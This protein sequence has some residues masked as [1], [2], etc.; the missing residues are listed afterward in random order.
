MPPNAKRGIINLQ[1]VVLCTQNKL[2][3]ALERGEEQRRN[4]GVIRILIAV[5]LNGRGTTTK[6]YTIRN[7]RGRGH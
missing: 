3:K 4:H 2:A 5:P 6:A 1:E 7:C